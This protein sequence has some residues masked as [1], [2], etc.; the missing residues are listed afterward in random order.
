MTHQVEREH[1]KALL[2]PILESG[3]GEKLIGQFDD[4]IRAS[5][6]G[7]SAWDFR[8][9]IFQLIVDFLDSDEPQ[10]VRTAARIIRRNKGLYGGL[11]ELDTIVESLT[12][13]TGERTI[14][15]ASEAALTLGFL[16]ST[17]PRDRELPSW[18]GSNPLSQ[19][20]MK[21]LDQHELV[22]ETPDRPGF[23][24]EVDDSLVDD[25]IDT[26]VDN[27]DRKD[28]KRSANWDVGEACT[29]AI[30]FIGYQ[31]PER[32]KTA[33]PTL[34]EATTQDDS[35]FRAILYALSSIGYS[36]PDLLGGD[37]IQRIEALAE[38]KSGDVPWG[39]RVQAQVANRKVGHAPV[40]LGKI[41]TFPGP[42]LEPIFE[43]LFRFMLGKFP[44]Y[45]EE[46]SN[47]VVDIVDAR[48][49][50][51]IP[52]L[53]DE[54]K[55]VVNG[56]AR[57]FSFPSNLMGILKDVS[58]VRPAVM[59]PVA[60]QAVDIYGLQGMEHYWYD[61]ASEFLQNVYDANPSHVPS[62]LES[63]LHDFLRDENRHS[64]KRSTEELLD[65]II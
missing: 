14:T 11:S 21:D 15:T 54:L 51:A 27:I 57:T 24:D 22:P 39:I 8:E 58:E 6:T 62:G 7:S 41:G 9:L 20:G 59:E 17:R 45:T 53:A 33:I 56:D 47:A 36:R 49:N 16:L 48:P 12:T 46:V 28:Y 63:T 37:V 38:N 34:L 42:D 52:L 13:I 43:K 44:S 4:H 65:T 29:L 18:D 61:L 19:Q 25:A 23:I 40:W 26:L 3:D 60:K 31:S 30:G 64:V 2:R 35:D 50:D 32:V 5:P 10:A 55:T 1:L